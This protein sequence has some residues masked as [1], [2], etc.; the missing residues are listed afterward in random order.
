M[1]ERDRAIRKNRNDWRPSDLNAATS[2][3]AR[4]VLHLSG[5]IVLS[6]TELSSQL[7]VIRAVLAGVESGASNA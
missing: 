5:S 1:A 2:A 3:I 6:P 4:V 7:D